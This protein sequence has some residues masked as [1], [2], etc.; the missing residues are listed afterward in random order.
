MTLEF[1]KLAGISGLVFIASMFVILIVLGWIYQDKIKALFIES[2]NQQLRTEIFVDQIRLEIVRTFP[3]ASLTFNHITI[4]GAGSGNPQDTLLYAEKLQLQFRVMDMIRKNYTLKHIAISNGCIHPTI[5][6]QGQSNFDFWDKT[7][8]SNQNHFHLNLQRIVLNNIRARYLDESTNHLIDIDIARASFSGLFSHTTYALTANGDMYAN[9]IVLD[10]ITVIRQQPL[11]LDMTLD[12]ED[13]T[14]F[15]FGKGNLWINNHAFSVTGTITKTQEGVGFDTRIEGKKLTL[16]NLMNDLP[17]IMKDYTSGYRA[18]GE[19]AF[20]AHITGHYTESENPGI[21]AFFSLQQGE[22][23]HS[24]TKLKLKALSFTG[25]YHNGEQRRA[26][27]TILAIND[28]NTKLNEG[29]IRGQFRLENLHMPHLSLN[30]YADMMASEMV[31]L[32]KL[33][34]VSSST[35]RVLMDVAFQ[36]RMSEK[37]KFTGQDLVKAR[38]SGNISA[39]DLG[40]TLKNSPNNHHGINGDLLFRNNDLLVEV[41]FGNIGRSD[42]AVS[43]YFRNILPYLFLEEE[44]IQVDASLYSKLL[45]FDELLQGQAGNNGISNRL[46]FSNR[47][48]FHLHAT[49]DQLRFR[50][51]QASNISGNVSLQNKRFNA[52]NVRFKSMN[53]NVTASGYIDST[54]PDRIMMVCSTRLHR[55]DVHQMFYQMGNFG[56]QGIL[57]ENI[58]GIMTSDFQFSSQWTP[59]MEI[60]WNSLQTTASIRVEDG[61]LVDYEPMKALG[62]FLRVDDLSRVT[63]STLENNIHIKDRMI[64]IPDM[65]INSNILNLKLSGKHSFENQIEYHLQVLLSEI[66]SQKNRHRRNP[67]E[68][69][70]DIIDDGLGRTTLFL[71]VSGHINDP[72]FSYDHRGVRQKLVNDLRQERETMLDALK[73]EFNFLVRSTDDTD[74][75]KPMSEKQ[76]EMQR[77]RKQEEGKMII[78]WEDF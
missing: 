37:N 7:A 59:A 57:D 18:K 24:T 67:Q 23:N 13:N 36:G 70:G 16:Q 28:I 66:L 21:E 48:G 17:D 32:L 29:M 39:K 15:H 42:F 63:F 31:S 1:L 73:K 55:V 5:D 77:L 71:K 6:K 74:A 26:E 14:T 4:M 52:E 65:E 25:T 60:D 22:L 2:I 72:V 58:F 9:K 61:V 10:S 40:F 76:K 35:G 43:G 46:T 47:L 44:S 75:S 34:Q 49:V 38:A 11:K 53:G 56:Q 12:V 68:Q 20:V 54:M 30:L 27:T 8:S 62:R 3:M 45:D 41:F 78:E 33:D 64:I 50:R 51:F 19:L 69:Y